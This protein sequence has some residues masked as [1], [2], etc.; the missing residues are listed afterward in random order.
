MI[1]G[2]QHI[3]I[4]VR[5]RDNS[6]YFYNNGLGFAVPISMH[7]GNCNGVV[8]IIKENQQRNVVIALNPYGGGL[9]EIF[10]YITKTPVPP[11]PEVDFTYNGFL[12]YGL[13]VRNVNGALERI[14][15]Y[16]GEV[17][18]FQNKFSPMDKFGW[19][20]AIFKDP[21]GIYGILI[22]YPESNVGYGGRKT[23]IGGVEY[24]AI[25]VSNIKTSI[26]FYRNILGYDRIIYQWE[27][28]CP[29]WET[30]FGRDR[31][32]KRALLARSGK[33]SGTFK[34]FLRGGMIELIEVEGNKGKHNFEGRTWGDIGL[35][36]VC[37]D[38]TDIEKTLAEVTG[39]GAEI[40][41]SP[42]KQDMG[43]NTFATFAYIKDP[44]GSLLEFADIESLPVPYFMIRLFVRPSIV[45]IAKK[46]GFL[47]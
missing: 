28:R 40:V 45:G 6:Y 39:K 36:E 19:K 37:F 21:D 44:D 13:K 35:M 25:G 31:K 3:G 38:V 4:G 26:E 33:P 29:E 20:T 8:P 22:E 24:I 30:L 23:R 14:K 18:T 1:N 11:P 15:N 10:Q 46:F 47:K 16:G 2:L 17:I 34:H 7:T 41:V 9:V 5:N 32:L 43:M 27:G 42:Y 12:F